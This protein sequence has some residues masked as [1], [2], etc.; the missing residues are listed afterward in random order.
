[1]VGNYQLWHHEITFAQVLKGGIMAVFNLFIFFC[2]DF[3]YIIRRFFYQ[4]NFIFN[5]PGRF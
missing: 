4:I 5:K 2:I 3:G 1:V